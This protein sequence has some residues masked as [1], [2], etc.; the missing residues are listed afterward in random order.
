MHGPNESNVNSLEQPYLCVGGWYLGSEFQ[1]LVL[2]PKDIGTLLPL[3]TLWMRKTDQNWIPGPLAP[4]PPILEPNKLS[5]DS[6]PVILSRGEGG[7]CAK[8]L[9]GA[10][11]C[12]QVASQLGC[13]SEL[14][15]REARFI[16][17]R[18]RLQDLGGGTPGLDCNLWEEEQQPGW[19]QE[20]LAT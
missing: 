11:C 5:A 2:D 7:K 6:E 9:L 3:A 10:I 17:S 4:I 16:L 1:W 13:L 20:G 18:I 8:A 19:P 14:V 12:A 15:W